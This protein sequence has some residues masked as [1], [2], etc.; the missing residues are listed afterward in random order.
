MT[1]PARAA[2]TAQ[3]AGDVAVPRGQAE[4]SAAPPAPRSFAHGGRWSAATRCAPLPRACATSVQP[5]TRH[6]PASAPPVLPPPPLRLQASPSVLRAP[7][8]GGACPAALRL[9]GARMGAA[10]SGARWPRASGTARAHPAAGGSARLG[11]T[12]VRPGQRPRAPCPPFARA[13]RAR[14]R[15]GIPRGATVRRCAPAAPAPAPVATPRARGPGSAALARGARCRAGARHQRPTPARKNTR[16]PLRGSRCAGRGTR[17][18]RQSKPGAPSS[19][20][21]WR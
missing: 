10:P 3:R 11:L 4:A 2:W 14:L 6:R 20:F 1:T 15:A 21:S 8:F 5:R 17:P 12:S 13:L 16:S 18:P 19:S 7:S 9:P